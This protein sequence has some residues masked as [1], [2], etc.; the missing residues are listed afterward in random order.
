MILPIFKSVKFRLTIWYALLLVFILSLFGFFMHAELKRVLYRD[1]DEKLSG[2]ALTLQATL[3]R[4]L[5]RFIEKLPPR[6]SISFSIGLDAERKIALREMIARWE[7]VNK[8]LERSPVATRVVGM[9]HQKMISNLS[10]WQK[11]VIYPN[12]ERD[13][14]FMEKGKSHQTIHFKRKPMRLY[15][16]L[17]SAK[18][19]PLFIIQSASSLVEIQNTLQRLAF[20]LWLSVPGTVAIA[21]MA[22]WFLVKRSFR[23]FDSMIR[24]ARQITAAYLKSRLPRSGAGDEVDRLAETLNEMIDRI[25]T[26]TRAIQDFSS[27]ISHELRT[28]LAII[29]GEIDLALRKARSPEDLIKT[30]RTVE[31]EVNELIRLVDDLMLLVRSDAKQLRFEKKRVALK[32]LLEAVAERFKERAKAKNIE[33]EAW[34]PQ[35]AAVMGDE[36]Y[37]KRL[38][39]NLLDN[40]L[41][42]TLQG[43]KIDVRLKRMMEKAAVEVSDTGMGMELEIQGKVFSRFYRSDQARS[44]EGAGLGL[45]IAKA[46]CDGHGAEIKIDSKPGEGTKVQILFPI[47]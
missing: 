18:N 35:D 33:L 1:I 37:L 16:H 40:A 34:L 26:S 47:S 45:N 44:Y 41:K 14:I 4:D 15:Y 21:C 9:D 25:E 29:R 31:E 46:I 27:D 6:S 43:G 32:P 17:V 20:I 36:L 11:E 22:G 39:S 38:F 10:G 23:P 30:L 13:S 19:Y 28:P 42:F 3:L 24:E 2:E 5:D 12:F 8:T 7:K